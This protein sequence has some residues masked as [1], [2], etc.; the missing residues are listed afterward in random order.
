MVPAHQR[1]EAESDAA[2]AAFLR[3]IDEGELIVGDGGAQ[4]VLDHAALAHGVA[5]GGFK[6]PIG[7]AA[8]GLDAVEGCVCC[9]EQWVA[10]GCVIRA[11]RDADAG[12]D[13][14]EFGDALT[15]VQRLDDC[16]C[17]FG[18]DIGAGDV[19]QQDAE[20]VATEAGEQLAIAE[21][22]AD[23]LG[24]QLQ[25]LVAGRMAKQIVDLL[26]AIEVEAQHRNLA[27]G[28]QPRDALVELFMEHAAI[29]QAGQRSRNAPGIGCGARPRCVRAGRARR[30]PHARHRRSAAPGE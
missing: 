28:V 17:E 24:R 3:L 2:L 5:H 14:A 12:G 20:L 30:R 26:E 8:I 15:R 23:A 25:H 29:G 22:G 7:G 27:V 10:F 16:I 19:R 21:Q 9:G 6:E 11:K 1:L 18:C 4:V 13:I